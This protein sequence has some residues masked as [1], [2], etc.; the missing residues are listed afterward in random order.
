MAPNG[1]S[2]REMLAALDD[3][4]ARLRLIEITY[5]HLLK[6]EHRT[7]EEASR[8]LL[9][10]ARE[11]LSPA[12]VRRAIYRGA[13]LA[14]RPESEGQFE[15]EAQRTRHRAELE[16][17][18]R[19]RQN[20]VPLTLGIGG[21][22]ALIPGGIT[23]GEVL[24][25]V[26]GEGGLKTSLLLHILCAYANRGGR[27]LF[28]SLDMPPEAIELR[29]LMRILNCGKERAAEHVKRD[30]DEYRRARAVLEECDGNLPVMGGPMGLDKMRDSILMSKADVVGIDYVTLVGDYKSEL[31]AAREV[32]KAI[33]QWRKSWGVTF[34]LLSQMSRESKRDAI[35][36]G[37]AGH[38][39]GGSSLEQLVDYELELIRDEPLSY[40]GNP[41]LIATLRKNRAGQSGV[42]FEIYP[43]FPSLAF[44]ERADRV[45][46]ERK[47]KPLF[48][49]YLF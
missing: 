19:H 6:A 35:Q 24:H 16:Q 43:C 30:T 22:D 39:I 7:Q 18:L 32:T 21:I 42:S 15:I 38:G 40:G 41:R 5:P 11:L 20:L 37:T 13:L 36:G 12:K 8:L 14:R 34:V 47:R 31:D 10:S 4:D 1:M 9:Y 44:M 27:A 2:L 46:R 26:G 28:F 3:E 45:E 29:L 33:R 23:A 17:A 49:D 25:I 48:G